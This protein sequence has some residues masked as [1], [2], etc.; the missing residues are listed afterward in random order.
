[1]SGS[2][3][4]Q[5]FNQRHYSHPQISRRHYKNVM[6]KINFRAL[7][8]ILIFCSEVNN[9]RPSVDSVDAASWHA[10]FDASMGVVKKV[11][12]LFDVIKGRQNLISHQRNSITH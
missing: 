2:A 4:L 5:G 11:R 10:E 7:R 3:V 8:R 9:Y 6:F 1:L 12:R